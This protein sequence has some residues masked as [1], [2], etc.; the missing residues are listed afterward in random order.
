MPALTSNDYDGEGSF[1]RIS[2]MIYFD[3][4]ICV[5]LVM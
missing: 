2:N 5:F 1:A 4:C 3:V